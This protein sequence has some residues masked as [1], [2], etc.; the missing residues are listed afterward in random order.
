M[1]K[2]I[3]LIKGAGEGCDYTIACNRKWEYLNAKN[4]NDAH[5]ECED[6]CLGWLGTEAP[7]ES[8]EILEFSKKEDFDVEACEAKLKSKQ[9]S[10]EEEE[11]E[12]FEKAELERLKKKYESK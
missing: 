5:K 1:L 8:I 2:Y 9:E 4:I 10:E 7:I 11:I 3:A 12:E 6:I